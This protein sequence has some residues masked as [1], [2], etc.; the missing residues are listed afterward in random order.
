MTIKK[1]FLF[2]FKQFAFYFAFCLFL[3]Y[4]LSCNGRSEENFSYE[5]YGTKVEFPLTVQQAVNKYKV[6][7]HQ[8]N[9]TGVAF[10]SPCPPG[11][12]T[13]GVSEVFYV[14]TA[15]DYFSSPSDSLSRNIYAIKF[16]F[17]NQN[18]HSFNKIKAQLEEDF[19]D[20]F[21]LNHNIDS[22]EPYYQL[23]SDKGI[24]IIIEFYPELTYVFDE[25]KINNPQAWAISFCYNL[26]KYSIRDYTKY[27]RNYDAQ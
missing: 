12:P 16:C 15:D 10:S 13:N 24:S 4:I 19:R 18:I 20:K 7:P 5:F 2:L 17:V 1:I 21:D 11:V 22:K 8:Y 9:R 23:N 26:G 25:N 3:L 6:L 14:D 27:E